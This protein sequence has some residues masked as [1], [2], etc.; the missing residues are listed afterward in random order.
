LS[1]LENQKRQRLKKK[2]E[3]HGPDTIVLMYPDLSAHAHTPWVSSTDPEL[4]AAYESYIKDNE[5]YRK[6]IELFK[7]WVK[8]E[9]LRIDNIRT[10]YLNLARKDR[11][12]EGL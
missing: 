4:Q 2:V 10:R 12:G 9:G 5:A 11:Y 8:V 6:S 1:A 7:N 3:K